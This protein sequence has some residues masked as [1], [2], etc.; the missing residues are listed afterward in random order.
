MNS[1]QSILWRRIDAPGHDACTVAAAGHG[2]RIQG[3]A[4]FQSENGVAHLKYEVHCNAQ[5]QTQRATIQGVVGDREIDHRVR[6]TSNGIWTLNH[7]TQPQ[8]AHCS[9]LDLALTPATNTIAIRRLALDMGAFAEVR[10]AWLDV[11]GDEFSVLEQRY[12][13]ES[14]HHYRYDSARFDF[15]A[16]LRVNDFGLVTDYPGLWVREPGGHG[17]VAE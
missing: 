8:L 17:E 11:V 1:E 13:R 6:R 15:H 5:W 2:W 14:N 12:T 16:T 7:I 9:D 3:A 4:A 10:T